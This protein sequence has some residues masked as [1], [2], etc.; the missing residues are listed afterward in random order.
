MLGEHPAVVGQ[1]HLQGVAHGDDEGHP[2]A[3]A[4]EDA[5]DHLLRLAGHAATAETRPDKPQ[6][7]PRGKEA[8]G[9]GA[10]RRHVLQG[11]VVSCGHS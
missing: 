5:A 1:Q 9:N 10:E 11:G 7:G 3:R 6:V 2:E 8:T 4:K